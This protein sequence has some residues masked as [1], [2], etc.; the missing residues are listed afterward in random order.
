MNALRKTILTAMLVI[1]AAALS[2]AGQSETV[3]NQELDAEIQADVTRALERNSRVDQDDITVVA[4][5]GVVTLMG[6]VASLRE[7]EAAIRTARTVLGVTDVIEQLN[8]VASGE[9]PAETFVEVDVRS[10][11]ETSA[12]VDASGI[13][14][15]V[16]GSEVTLLGSV[17]SLYARERAE[18]IVLSLVGVEEVT[19]ELSVVPTEERENSAIAADVEQA[20]ARNAIVDE[21]DVSVVVSDGVV[22][23]SGTVDS[24]AERKEA[25]TAALLTPGVV[26]L[27]DQLELVQIAGDITPSDIREVV[28]EQLEWDVR[29]DASDID[30]VVE[31]PRVTLSGTVESARAKQVAVESA[32]SVRGVTV[33]RDQLQVELVDE[34]GS[35]T[36]VTRAVRNN[37]RFNTGI[38]I[39][40]LEVTRTDGVVTISGTVE[41]AWQRQEAERIAANTRGVAEVINGIVVLPETTRTDTTIEADI[42]EAIRESSFVDPDGISV[43]VTDSVVTLTGEVE[44]W[45]EKETTVDFALQTEGVT[46]VED[47]LRVRE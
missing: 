4:E 42:K 22:V 32:E 29:V 45:F 43:D 31:G 41:E 34:I 7:E 12:D 5:E 11:L 3:T 30:V 46:V 38:E 21:T 14:V 37:L 47:E 2:A 36:N 23:L 6:D 17:G 20:L 18:E 25:R 28:I 13:V 24:A 15:D 9:S 26:E 33:V 39:E 16:Q 10:A 44:T 35:R 27:E 8:V 19:N 40:D 1:G